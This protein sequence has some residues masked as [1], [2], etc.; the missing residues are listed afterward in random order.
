MP[1][2]PF[3][4]AS[5]ASYTSYTPTTPPHLLPDL[6]H[7]LFE[8]FLQLPPSSHPAFRGSALRALLSS[9]SWKIDS[10]PPSARV[11]AYCAVALGATIFSHPGIIGPGGAYPASFADR[12]FFFQGADLR[13]YGRH[14]AA[15]CHTLHSRAVRLAADAGT[16]LTVSEEDAAACYFLD[17][18]DRHESFFF[19]HPHQADTRSAAWALSHI[20]QIRA[21][22]ASWRNT[23]PDAVQC[24]WA[25]HLL[26]LTPLT[27]ERTARFDHAT[28]THSHHPELLLTGPNPPSLQQL[29]D[30]LRAN[31][32]APNGNLTLQQVIF[33]VLRPFLSYV[34]RLARELSLPSEK[35]TGAYARRHS[36]AAPTSERLR[37]NQP[38]DQHPAT[39]VF[40]YLSPSDLPPMPFLMHLGWNVL[41]ARAQFCV[42]EADA[43]GGAPP[44]G[45]WIF[46]ILSN[47]PKAIG[48]AW[49]LQAVSAPLVGRLDAYLGMQHQQF[50]TNM[51]MALP[52]MDMRYSGHVSGSGRGR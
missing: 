34:T 8:C 31:I 14:R 5:N 11:L 35:V 37:S 18:L 26:L 51:G 39:P 4:A 43:S 22:A 32:Q 24:L 38:A 10:L 9:A 36:L 52:T 23:I 42:D 27:D 15:M 6:V 20:T 12:A 33:N 3:S 50:P 44:D 40:A 30:T 25:A 7:T 1:F 19:P 47:A 49:E 28:K 48:Y 29:L 21:L 41:C 2:R 17:A 16:M 46:E 13:E 45:L